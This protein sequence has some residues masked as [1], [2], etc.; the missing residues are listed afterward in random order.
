M[1]EAPG[2]GRF[3]IVAVREAIWLAHSPIVARD[4]VLAG[5]RCCFGCFFFFSSPS[6]SL[7]LLH[8]HHIYTYYGESY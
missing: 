3:I 7:I 5:C 4:A 1:G 2:N 6:G 8:I